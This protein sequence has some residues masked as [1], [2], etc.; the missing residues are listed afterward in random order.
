MMPSEDKEVM[1]KLAYGK[2]PLV[3]LVPV[4]KMSFPL[5]DWEAKRF[6]TWQDEVNIDGKIKPSRAI[7]D[8]NT[9]KAIIVTYFMD[10]DSCPFLKDNKCTIYSTRRAYICRLFPFN[11]GPFIKTGTDPNKHNM[12]GTC[13]GLTNIFD[14]IPED[15]EE[16]V[17][18][19]S[20]AFPDGSFENAVEFDHI[21]AWINYTIIDLMRKKLIR[22]AMNYPYDLFLKR[23]ENAEKIDFTDFLEESGYIKSKDDLIRDFDDNID[24]KRLIDDFKRKGSLSS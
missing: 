3:Q 21:T 1:E 19:L 20:L 15:Y 14:Q 5:W 10:S 11:R 2:L 8:L 4:E 7:L 18:F 6:K 17:S 9:N 13:A 16:M 24:A 23:F 12:F 22:P